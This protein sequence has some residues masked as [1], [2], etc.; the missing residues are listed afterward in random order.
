[1]RK[2]YLS[3][4]IYYVNSHPHLG[5]LYVTLVADTIARYRRQRGFDT[6]FLTGTDEHGQNIERAAAERGLSVK[7]HVDGYVA[8]FQE[9]FRT[10]NVRE[11]RWIRTTDHYHEVGVAE[12]WRRLRDAGAIYKGEYSGWY[13]V[14]C[15]TFQSEDEWIVGEDGI[16][17]CRIHEKPLDRVAEESYFFR[18]SEFQTPLLDY[19]EQHP[20]F[21]Q[22]ETRRNEV[23][24][25][26]GSGLEDLSISRVSVSWGI[27]VPDDPRHT[28]YV[29]FDALA[30]YITAVGFGNA[31]ADP[32]DTPAGEAEFRNYWPAD[33]HLV[34]KD[35]LRFHTVYWPA[36]LLAAGIELPKTV[37]AH[38][39]WMSGGRKMSKSLGNVIDLGV[40]RRHF[41]PDTVRYF[42]LREMV[43]GQDGDFTYEALI[44]RSNGD[45]AAG[46]GNLSSRTLTMVQKYFDGEIPRAGE[47]EAG[48]AKHASELRV[49]I[50]QARR[51]FDRE[52]ETYNFSRALEAVWGAIGRVDKFISA[53]RP[54]DLAKDDSKRG[55]LELVLNTSI[56]ALRHFTVLLVP[57]LPETTQSIWQQMGET[58]EAASIN[59]NGPEELVWGARQGGRVGEIKPVFPR[60]DKKNTMEEI[61]QEEAASQ[62]ARTLDSNPLTVE[63]P[64]PGVAYIG[65]EDFSRVELRVGEVLTAE[66]V[67][68]ADR[69]LRFSIDLGE[70]TPR[71]ILAGIA[72]YYEPEKLV[73]RKLIVVANL[74]PRKLRGLESQGM[75]LAAAVGEEGRPVLAGFLEDV[76]NGAKLK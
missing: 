59:P 15:N 37:Y 19:Y 29:W 35:I 47:A 60:L 2:Y 31:H 36:L 67:P 27:P 26:V 24:S 25:F 7:A 42:S 13:C 5:H 39:L 72:Q 11:D 23:I 71:Q 58:G 16:P 41:A 17:V 32:P 34:G 50:D 38:G 44:D 33:L 21:I 45:L 61:K 56:E 65:I 46:L 28:I 4:P 51:E 54:W 40:L 43:F 18:L 12:L 8:E 10:F 64:A 53:A 57:V 62:A 9:M 22:P 70:A 75:I 74:A 6:F 55:S 76:P 48:I 1:M 63:E 3:T 30:N 49:A 66:R 68:K 69:L 73:G 14:G 52:F 20:E